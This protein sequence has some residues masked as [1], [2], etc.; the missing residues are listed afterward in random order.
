MEMEVLVRVDVIEPK[1]ARAKRYE[2]CLDL[3]AK[4]PP[5]IAPQRDV[6]AEPRHVGAEDTLAIDQARHALGRQRRTAFDQ[7]DVQAHAQP[8]HFPRPCDRVVCGGACHHEACGGEDAAL[9]RDLDSVV[10]LRREPEIVGG[11]DEPFHI[12]RTDSP[13]SCPALCRAYTSSLFWP[14]RGWSERVRP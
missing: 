6:D 14:R 4:L 8:R 5:Q 7:H 10:D 9:M 12:N 1:P 11:D 3:G 13:P 2:L